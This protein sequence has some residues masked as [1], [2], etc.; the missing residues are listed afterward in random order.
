[1]GSNSLTCGTSISGIMRYSAVSSTI[2]YCNGS[3]WTS[4]GPSAA[5]PVAF[6]VNKGG[7]NQTVA[8]SSEVLPTWPSKDFDTIKKF[9][10]NRYAPTVPGKYL[11][12]SRS[13]A[14][15]R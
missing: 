9:A 11:S 6:S 15:T 7:S 1:V 14:R 5:Q 4:M 10:S 3:A 2:E 13:T 12:Y 8:T